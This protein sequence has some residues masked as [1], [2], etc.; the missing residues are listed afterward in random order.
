MKTR[1]TPQS[2]G[3]N[4]QTHHPT[5][6]TTSRLMESE[7]SRYTDLDPHGRQIRLVHLLPGTKDDPIKCIL[8]LVS[9]DDKPVYQTLSYVWG[10][11]DITANI[12]LDAKPFAVTTNLHAAL[13]RL[14]QKSEARIIWIDALSIDQS[15]P[16]ERTHQ[17]GLMG[18]IY[19]QCEEVL[20]W[21]G[22]RNTESEGPWM[23]VEDAPARPWSDYETGPSWGFLEH[24]VP[25][26]DSDLTAFV[27]VYMMSCM[28]HVRD[29]PF[30]T[31]RAG[32]HL[33][34]SNDYVNGFKCLDAFLDL[35]YWSRIWVVQEMILPP[36]ATVVYG[37]VVLPWQMF[38]DAER[39]Y[40]E[41]RDTCCRTEVDR[42]IIAKLRD[43]VLSIEQIRSRRRKEPSFD[44]AHVAISF[45][46]L[47]ATDPRDKI[48]ALLGLVDDGFRTQ[49]DYT[50][51]THEA[52]EKVTL[53]IIFS[54]K[55][56]RSLASNSIRPLDFPSWVC[57]WNTLP[58]GHIRYDDDK[59]RYDTCLYYNASAS[60]AITALYLSSSRL[61]VAG[62]HVDIA[63]WAGD[64][65]QSLESTWTE[66]TRA[67]PSGEELLDF[68]GLKEGLEQA[69][70]GGGSWGDAY[71]RTLCADVWL[72]RK[73][74][75][76]WRRTLPEDKRKFE[77]EGDDFIQIGG[78]KCDPEVA[79]AIDLVTS[80]RR[81]FITRT[82]YLGLG[83]E[84]MEVGDS[85][86]VINGSNVPLVLREE[87]PHFRDES[88]RTKE[89]TTDP[90]Y[91]HF[92]LIGQCYVHGIM[93]GEACQDA[94][95]DIELV[96]C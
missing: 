92:R 58:P 40:G 12:Q 55:S 94:E 87:V 24:F 47:A 66:V 38:A 9:L 43:A 60:K 10:D 52:Y 70:E 91:P 20:M 96:L 35:P 74:G 68:A 7:P 18:T 84:D 26:F 46:H 3:V 5:T 86:Y 65:C 22:D 30:L 31:Q 6:C 83:P 13:R 44:L 54:T 67:I 16:D 50:I 62:T 34:V 89:N 45:I 1:L 41:H 88:N 37:S 73:V 85:V 33:S 27:I 90:T 2:R 11:K 81:F 93:D 28:D 78:M 23:T 76:T 79:H 42:L 75:E 49:S 8:Q 57:V 25:A 15:S 95:K 39:R 4:Y 72:L 51:S 14:R 71:W 82:G 59:L 19:E 56:L 69:Y 61:L 32:N 29:L 36:R 80:N 64:A 53:D 48:Y 77:Y 17:V 63:I 21:L